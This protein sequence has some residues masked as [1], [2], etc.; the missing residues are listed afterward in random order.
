M[1]NI[2]QTKKK[3]FRFWKLT[4]YTFIIIEAI[5]L[6][7]IAYH[8]VMSMVEQNKYPAL[9]QLVEVDDKKL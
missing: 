6:S 8:H 9:G 4:G 7:W 1:K 3:K 2:V 5:L